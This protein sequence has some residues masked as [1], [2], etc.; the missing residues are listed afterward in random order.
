MGEGKASLESFMGLDKEND[1]LTPYGGFLIR[2]DTTK[3]QM[4]QPFTLFSLSSILGY[5]F[6]RGVYNLCFILPQNH[7][8]FL[9]PEDCNAC[10]KSIF[11]K[12][13]VLRATQTDFRFCIRCNT[14]HGPIGNDHAFNYPK[15]VSLHLPPNNSLWQSCQ[16]MC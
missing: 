6:S 15:Y 3:S 7:C 10:P 16:S 5:K 13:Q 1:T 2:S 12:S 14:N 8:S 9:L 11:Q 4:L